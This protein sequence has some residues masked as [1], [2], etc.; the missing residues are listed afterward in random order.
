MVSLSFAAWVG[1]FKTGGGLWGAYIPSYAS[2]CQLIA[3]SCWLMELE[4]I[5]K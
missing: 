4:A 5:H 1:Y 3:A 2:P